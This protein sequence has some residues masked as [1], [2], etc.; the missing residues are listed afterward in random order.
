MITASVRS[1]AD[2]HSVEL[3]VAG[4]DLVAN[5]YNS[6]RVVPALVTLT[7]VRSGE[8][9]AFWIERIKVDG[10][11]ARANGEPS[12]STS[13]IVFS[14]D[15][16]RPLNRPGEAQYRAPEWLRGLADRHRPQGPLLARVL[17]SEDAAI[18]LDEKQ[19]R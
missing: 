14:G 2:T 3:A 12:A 18:E 7:Y 1:V 10:P 16:L 11:R 13:E 4:A 17:P 19:S 9:A 15:D 8:L 6:V 5:P